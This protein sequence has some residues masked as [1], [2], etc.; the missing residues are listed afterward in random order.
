ME[1]SYGGDNDQVGRCC[2]CFG[3][4]NFR[5]GHVARAA[6]STGRHDHA[7]PPSPPTPT[8]Q[9]QRP[10]SGT[11]M[12]LSTMRGKWHLHV[13]VTSPDP[14]PGQ[15]Q[16]L[17]IR[18]RYRTEPGGHNKGQGS[19]TH[20]LPSHVSPIQLAGTLTRRAC[21]PA[22]L[23]HLCEQVRARSFIPP[24]APYICCSEGRER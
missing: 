12:G 3:R 20:G 18:L 14:P 4:R 17:R 15:P 10:R 23:A 22:V 21:L 7:S 11:N 2:Y 19:R 5:P 9:I 6:S 24:S 16:V 13:C 8:V 1:G